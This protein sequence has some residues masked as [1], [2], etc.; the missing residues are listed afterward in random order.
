MVLVAQERWLRLPSRSH[1]ALRRKRGQERDVLLDVFGP[2]M[3][4][5]PPEVHRSPSS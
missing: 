3:R 2:F 1:R 5:I 4:T